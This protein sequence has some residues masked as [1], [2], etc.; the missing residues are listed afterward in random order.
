MDGQQRFQ[1]QF[2]TRLGKLDLGRLRILQALL[3]QRRM[4]QQPVDLMRAVNCDIL[5]EIYHT[6]SSTFTRIEP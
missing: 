2:G 6:E 4:I 3:L 5:T 1:Q